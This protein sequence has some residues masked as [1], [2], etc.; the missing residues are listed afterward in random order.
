MIRKLSIAALA[1]IGLA[2]SAEI[3]S[4]GWN[5]VAQLTC[6][7]RPKRASTSFRAPDCDKPEVR[8]SYIEKSYFKTVTEYRYETFKVPVEVQVRKSFYEPVTRY[9]TSSY[10]DQCSGRCEKVDIPYTAY[11]LRTE[12][13]T[14]TKMVEK[15]KK[16]PVEVTREFKMV[17]PVVTYYY[18]P[19]PVS[20]SGR[21]VDDGMIEAENAGSNPN[22]EIER[23]NSKKIENPGVP[24]VPPGNMPNNSNRNSGNGTSRVRTASRNS[25][26]AIRGELVEQDRITPKANSKLIFLNADDESKRIEVKTNQYGEFDTNIPAGDWYLYLGTGT[27]KAVYH[28]KLTMVEGQT[29]D[30]TVASK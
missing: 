28:S 14:E 5:N 3:A 7:C 4:A 13:G 20:G 10:Y 6:D 12:C 2:G 30:V 27:G 15:T 19:R 1:L 8:T 16:V 9:R 22:V 25:N 18:P 23:P 17:Q 21:I 29:R 24:A 11:R 26:A